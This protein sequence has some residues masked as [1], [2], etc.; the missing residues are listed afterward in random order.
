VFCLADDKTSEKTNKHIIKLKK[1]PEPF[2][3]NILIAQNNCISNI[4]QHLSIVP[5][6]FA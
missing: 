3:G 6:S 5:A 4:P 2:P 1:K